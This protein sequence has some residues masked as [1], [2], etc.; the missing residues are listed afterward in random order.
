MAT[1]CY[2]QGRG[3]ATN[4]ATMST[5]TV[6]SLIVYGTWY[7]LFQLFSY[8]ANLQGARNPFY[9]YCGLDEVRVL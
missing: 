6:V 9:S 2:K 3:T 8:I 7:L 1:Q 5:S 4:R